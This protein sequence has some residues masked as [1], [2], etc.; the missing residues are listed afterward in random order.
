MLMKITWLGA[1]FWLDFCGIGCDPKD[2]MKKLQRSIASADPNLSVCD[3]WFW[4][5]LNAVFMGLLR[6]VY[7]QYLTTSTV[8]FS[9]EGVMLIDW[10]CGGGLPLILVV[11]GALMFAGM[12]LGSSQLSSKLLSLCGVIFGALCLLHTVMVAY[13]LAAFG[14][15][16]MGSMRH[17]D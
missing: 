4:F 9:E 1:S 17:L 10:G 3:G 11:V 12:L 16:A 6:I 2:L 7:L 13:H 8:E 5:V 14:G 15:V